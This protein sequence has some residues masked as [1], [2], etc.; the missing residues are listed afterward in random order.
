MK[1]HTQR[2]RLSQSS[3]DRDGVE[4]QAEQ[5][6]PYATCTDAGR[7]CSYFTSDRMAASSPEVLH[8]RIQWLTQYIEDNITGANVGQNMPLKDKD[9]SQAVDE[10]A[11]KIDPSVNPVQIQPNGQGQSTSSSLDNELDNA[12]STKGTSMKVWNETDSERPRSLACLN[13]YFH[14]V[15]RAYPFVNKARIMQVQSVN[16][17]VVLIENDADSMMLY[18]IHAIGRTTLERSGKMSP[19]TGKEVQLPYTI[20]LQYCMEN[21]S[22][23]S[24]QILLL[25]ALYSL[26]DPHAPSPWTTAGILTRQA[27]AQGLTLQRTSNVDQALPSDEPLNRLFWSI[28]VLDRMVASSVGQP[29]GLFVP[30]VHIPLPAV[31]VSEFA[32]AQ[33]AEVSSMLLVTR[34]VIQLRR[35]ES[36]ITD[37]IFL[38]PRTD[39]RSLTP[40]D[41]VAII[42]ELHYAVDNWYSDGCL[43]CRPEASN[44]RIHDTMAWLNARYYQL[45]MLIHYPTPFNQPPRPGFH[46]HLLNVVQKYIHY[47]QVLLELGQLPLNFI[48]LTRFVPACLVLLYCFGHMTAMVFP[49]KQEIQSCIAILQSFSNGWGHAISLAQIMTE[50]S[51]VVSMYES[52][53]ASCLLPLQTTPVLRHAA[54]P[55]LYPRMVPLRAQLLEVGGRILGKANCYQFIEGWDAEAISSS[56]A[57]DASSSTDAAMTRDIAALSS[58]LVGTIRWDFL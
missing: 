42:S 34:H 56:S 36:K 25:L 55:S 38:R 9:A 44:V 8:A 19:L 16:V 3:P 51:S 4:M 2:Y 41:R 10:G 21:E 30:D 13:A 48:T 43:I 53:S 31:T 29:P 46:E 1:Y 28:Y 57:E 52:R 15:H 50:F 47:S 22:M 6:R 24:V 18:L 26:F 33:R 35:L 39:V 54:Q 27:M 23:D 14:H 7:K 49:A 17:N 20:I 37:A 40:S 11:G 32:S 58:P 12:E 45:L 5:Q